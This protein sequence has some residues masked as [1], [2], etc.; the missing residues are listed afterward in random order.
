MA[1]E[2]NPS[3]S[4]VAVL[5]NALLRCGILACSDEACAAC[6]LQRQNDEAWMSARSQGRQRHKWQCT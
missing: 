5:A 3:C 4:H 2:R 6:M 1:R